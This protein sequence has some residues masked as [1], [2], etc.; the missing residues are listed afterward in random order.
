MAPDVLLLDEPLSALD[1]LTRAKLQTEIEAI[2]SQERKTVV[3]ITN[4]VDEAILLADRIIPLKPGPDA[5]F[6]PEFRVPVRAAARSRRD[7]HE[8][9][10]Q[11]A[12]RRHHPISDGCR[13]A[14]HLAHARGRSH[15][16]KCHARPLRSWAA[17]RL[18]AGGR[19]GGR[20][21]LRRVL[22]IAQ[23]LFHPGGTA[24][25]RRRVRHADA[26]RRVCLAHRALRMRQVHG[27]VDGRRSQRYLQR[28]HRP[29]Q[30]GDYH[31]RS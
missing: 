2:W 6:G 21:A 4:D 23:S 11:E 3:M 31:R 26:Q 19:D 22:S 18:S 1:A 15:A 25:R 29:R 17:T 16:S 5:N 27:A 14:A 28:R 30:Q 9:E 8:P 24:H 7:Q 10:L 12:A 20:S 13:P